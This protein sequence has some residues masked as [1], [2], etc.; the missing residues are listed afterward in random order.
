M[1]EIRVLVFGSTGSGKTS[2]C[3]AISGREYPAE[4]NARGVTFESNTYPYFS[5]E[6]K[7]IIITDTIG[8]D[9]S[10][11]GTVLPHEAIQQI[12]KLLNA[13]K[14]G[15]NLLIH[16]MK[17]PRITQSHVKNYNFF[18][19]RLTGNNIPVILVV[20]GCENEEPMNSWVDRN[21]HE[22]IKDNMKYAQIH[23]TCFAKGGRL[24]N[25]YKELRNESKDIIL[26]SILENSLATPYLLYKNRSDAEKLVLRLWNS[27]C[28]F[29]DLDKYRAGV[30]DNV[31]DVLCK[32]GVS[33]N[34]AEFLVKFDFLGYSKEFILRRIMAVL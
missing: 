20:T 13:S 11:S 26:K 21:G 27:F 8:L 24:E 17:A 3:N 1:S 22:F 31:L 10:N 19:D 30:G 28:D 5:H 16:V 4:S 9:E 23:A 33:Q 34:T 29:F 32:M 6:N 25:A 12:V 2:L 7:T 14:H 18:A 15:Y